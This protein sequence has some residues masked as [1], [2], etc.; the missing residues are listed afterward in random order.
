MSGPWLPVPP[1]PRVLSPAPFGDRP[2][3]PVLSSLLG[4]APPDPDGGIPPWAL[5]PG[6]GASHGGQGFN[7]A[8][9]TWAR[10]TLTKAL[11][12]R[13]KRLVTRIAMPHSG[14]KRRRVSAGM[15]TGKTS[16]AVITVRSQYWPKHSLRERLSARPEYSLQS[17]PSPPP[18]VRKV[19]P[20][21]G[22]RGN[23]QWSASRFKD[24][25]RWTSLYHASPA[26][27]LWGARLY[28]ARPWPR[29]S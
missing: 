25:I 14:G 22:T 15:T 10:L 5:V 27:G 12:L 1:P 11:V 23:L 6:F 19:S 7:L 28:F 3:R 29:T 2:R 13:L 21:T 4:G 17:G 24:G 20:L 26:A 9:W 16:S 8:N 18:L